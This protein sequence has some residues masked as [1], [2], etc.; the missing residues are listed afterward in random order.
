M[1]RRH[2]ATDGNVG[3]ALRAAIFLR[4]K[5]SRVAAGTAPP[6]FSGPR[7]GNP[8]TD[9]AFTEPCVGLTLDPGGTPGPMTANRWLE[10]QPF[11]R[12]VLTNWRN[13]N[14]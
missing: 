8:R 5:T 7:F 2:A 10:F 14:G 4:D 9:Q 13:R 1:V 11:H 3:G 12:T 6:T